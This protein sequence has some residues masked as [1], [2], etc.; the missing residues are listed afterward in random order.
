MGNVDHLFSLNGVRVLSIFWIVLGNTMSLLQ[1]HPEVSGE[2][3]VEVGLQKGENERGEKDGREREGKRVRT[4]E[5]RG[6]GS[7]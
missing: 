7:G 3:Q 4:T 5:G 2:F 1:K 6:G